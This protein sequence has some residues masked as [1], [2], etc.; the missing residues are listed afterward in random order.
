MTKSNFVNGG[1]RALFEV[2]THASEATAVLDRLESQAEDEPISCEML[3]P[4]APDPTA[5]NR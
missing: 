1:V 4:G 2:C 3:I 5:G